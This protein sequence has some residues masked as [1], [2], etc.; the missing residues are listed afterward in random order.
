MERDILADGP[1]TDLTTLASPDT[2][3]LNMVGMNKD[4]K[5]T[6]G[7]TITVRVIVKDTKGRPVLK[8]G[9]QVRVW[10]VGKEKT[11]RSAAVDVTDFN[12]GT[13]VASVPVLWSGRFEVR[14]A[15]NR[16]REFN[17]LALSL[18]NT[19]KMMNGIVGSFVS[20]TEEEVTMCSFIPVVPGYQQLCNLTSLN[21]G[22]PW[23]CG[24]PSTPGVQCQHW[25]WSSFLEFPYRYPLTDTENA[26][27]SQY[28]DKKAPCLRKLKQN[29]LLTAVSGQK[30][31]P[32]PKPETPCWPVKPRDTW[33]DK[34]PRGYWENNSWHLLK[35]CPLPQV[36]SPDVLKCLHNTTFLSFGDSNA[37]RVT[38]AIQGYTKCAQ[39]P[40]PQRS[41]HPNMLHVPVL[42]HC[43]QR[44]I[45][46]AWY[47]HSYPFFTGFNKWSDRKVKL[48]LRHAL[49]RLP[50]TSEKYVVM[51]HLYAHFLQVHTYAYAQQG[52]GTCY[53]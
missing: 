42:H 18:M 26:L 31:K 29:I 14:A 43:G 6:V 40:D 27:M 22:L 20:G 1:L 41:Y 32:A 46:V 51:I 11:P 3:Q 8:G 35:G 24:R 36:T 16:P 5:V 39:L 7:E 9:H 34:S 15:L 45:Y 13:Y 28:T 48:S 44:N 50:T 53:T 52:S 23:Y 21:W 12:N 47:P 19:M 37:I 17:R 4:R 25:A 33:E 38:E 49:Q 2:S 30:S 10:M